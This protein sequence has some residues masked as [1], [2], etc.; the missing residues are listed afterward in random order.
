MWLHKTWKPVYAYPVLAAI[1]A[2]LLCGYYWFAGAVSKPAE[3]SANTNPIE[4]KSTPL[5]TPAMTTPPPS[6]VAPTSAKTG[7]T[8]IPK[9]HDRN[10]QQPT[11]NQ[12]MTNSP[13]GIQAGRDVT[14]GQRPSPQ[15]TKEDKKP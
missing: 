7:D 3:S 4:Q 5:P 9:L 14:V 12:T 1:G 2:F 15:P 8:K 6:S 11:V 10:S 13:S